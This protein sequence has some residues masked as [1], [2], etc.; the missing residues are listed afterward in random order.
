MCLYIHKW[1]HSRPKP[2][3]SSI[4]GAHLGVRAH[5]H[6]VRCTELLNSTVQIYLYIRGGGVC[7][8]TTQ[9]FDQTGDMHYRKNRKRKIVREVRYL[10]TG[11]FAGTSAHTK[12]SGSPYGSSSNSNSTVVVVMVISKVYYICIQQRR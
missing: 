3:I 2:L 12:R 7:D 8:V 1:S 4:S 10:S 11:D 5:E 9:D 6:I